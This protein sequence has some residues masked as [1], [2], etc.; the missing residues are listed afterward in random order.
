MGIWW[1]AEEGSKKIVIHLNTSFEYTV[2]QP[3][4]MLTYL[5]IFRQFFGSFLFFL[6]D[7]LFQLLLEPV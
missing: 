7:K 1:G 2:R 6:F 3:R 4:A 5:F